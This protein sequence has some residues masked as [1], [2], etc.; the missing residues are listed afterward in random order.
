MGDGG[1]LF[2]V[3]YYQ[4]CKSC[5]STIKLVVGFFSRHLPSGSHNG[6][7]EKEKGG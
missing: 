2:T 3:S 6:E 7:K 4:P 5:D 1:G